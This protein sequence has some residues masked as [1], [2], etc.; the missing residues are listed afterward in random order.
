MIGRFDLTDWEWSIIARL[1]PAS[2]FAAA[3]AALARRDRPEARRLFRI[4]TDR[5]VPLL[6]F[7]SHK[8][9]LLPNPVSMTL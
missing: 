7:Y 6:E 9:E 2:G 8:R 1:L 4:A 5:E 3:E